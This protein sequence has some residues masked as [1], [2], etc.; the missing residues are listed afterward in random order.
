MHRALLLKAIG[1]HDSGHEYCTTWNDGSWCQCCSP[2][3]FG[4]A[5][6]ACPSRRGVVSPPSSEL[7][8]MHYLFDAWMKKH[9]P[10]IPWYRYGDA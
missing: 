3:L 7:S 1:K 5:L 4:A 8:F 6:P 10:N 2:G 9:F